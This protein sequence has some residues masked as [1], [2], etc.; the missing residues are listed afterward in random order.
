[1]QVWKTQ[2]TLALMHGSQTLEVYPFELGFA[3]NGHKYF[4]GDGKTPEGVYRIDRRN[5]NSQYHLS[6]GIS[7]PDPE[8]VAR[9]LEAGLDP[10][11]DIFIHGTPD[12]FVGRRDWTAG[13]I[14]VSNEAIEEI[15]AM[16]QDGT[17]IVIYP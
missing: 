3:P 11:G 2:R 7:Y 10:G 16:V 9:A 17:P 13:C 15:Y 8:D 12:M 4:E 5:P 6:V 1:M 14:A